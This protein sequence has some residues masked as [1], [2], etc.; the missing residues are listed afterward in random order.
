MHDRI[1]M[2]REDCPEKDIIDCNERNDSQKAFRRHL[3]GIWN[4]SRTLSALRNGAIGAEKGGAGVNSSVVVGQRSGQLSSQLTSHLPLNTILPLV[5]DRVNSIRLSVI[6][7]Y[8]D[9]T[10]LTLY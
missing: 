6:G 8:S 7:M 10:S 3:E 4:Q 9:I 2:D 5:P 1:H